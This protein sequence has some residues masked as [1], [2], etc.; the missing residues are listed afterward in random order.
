MLE[1]KITKLFSFN[2]IKLHEDLLVL[3]NNQNILHL[4]LCL[5][6]LCPFDLIKL[7]IPEKAQIFGFKMHSE[8]KVIKIKTEC[9][10]SQGLLLKH[11]RRHYYYYY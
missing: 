10:C 5:I 1:M 8:K 7:A 4:C 9:F 3:Q 11:K 6:S 2:V